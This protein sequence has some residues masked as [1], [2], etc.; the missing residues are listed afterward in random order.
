MSATHYIVKVTHNCNLQC[1]YCYVNKP[2][3]QNGSVP[4]AIMS[5][6]TFSHCLDAAMRNAL[7]NSLEQINVV[8]HGGEP[9]VAGIPLIMEYIE[10]T[11]K[12]EDTYNIGIALSLQTNGVLI[13]DAWISLLK[14]DIPNIGISFDG[15]ERIHDANRVMKNGKGSFEIIEKNIKKILDAGLSP[16]V[17]TVVQP[18]TSGAEVYH[19]FEELGIKRISFL[20]P[21]QNREFALFPSTSNHTPVADY[22]IQAF[23][24]WLYSSLD[25]VSVFLFEST[26]R[27]IYRVIDGIPVIGTPP[28]EWIAFTPEGDVEA[29]DCYGICEMTTVSRDDVLEAILICEQ[30]DI[31]QLQKTGAYLPNARQCQ[32]CCYASLCNGG[33]LPHRYSKKNGYDNPS[34]YCED[35]KKYFS[36]VI[37]RLKETAQVKDL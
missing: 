19:F 24:A 36:H 30:S 11:H 27:A 23:D 35:L 12:L 25:N 18:D 1:K 13:N 26:I 5:G 31:Y 7:N 8:L 16:G 14:K 37:S 10:R 21:A 32:E 22:L 2:A 17:L 9:L 6:E 20:I 29:G 4:A 15:P 34:Y 3:T 33:F 28:A